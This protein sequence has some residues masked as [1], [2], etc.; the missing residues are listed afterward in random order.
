M[1]NWTIA[2]IENKAVVSF[3]NA[4]LFVPTIRAAE[5]QRAC[6]L[7]AELGEPVLLCS[8]DDDRLK[9]CAVSE[10]FAATLSSNVRTINCYSF[11]DKPDIAYS[12]PIEFLSEFVEGLGNSECMLQ[13]GI[14]H[15]ELLVTDKAFR[16]GI[17]FYDQMEGAKR[18]VGRCKFAP[19]SDVVLPQPLASGYVNALELLKRTAIYSKEEFVE[20]AF[21][22][23]P[24]GDALLYVDG[25]PFD[26]ELPFFAHNQPQ[27]VKAVVNRRWLSKLTLRLMRFVCPIVAVDLELS[28]DALTLFVPKSKVAL[29]LRNEIPQTY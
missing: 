17:R 20:V 21:E 13:I 3:P 28:Q 8:G 23:M 27:T 16:G 18:I 2:K 19:G 14:D 26:F 15:D 24:T 7:F 4:S 1:S 9:F 12:V 25:R 11:Q 5:L 22:K 6:S 29:I 10:H